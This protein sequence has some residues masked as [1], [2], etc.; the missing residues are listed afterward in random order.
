MPER[1]HQGRPGA[2]ERRSFPRPPLWL[3]LLLLLL[4]VGGLV[5]ARHHREQVSKR[6]AHVIAEE[7]RTPEDVRKLKSE[8]AEM[9]LGRGEL[10]KELDGRA[11]FL[12]GLKSEDFYLSIDTKSRKIRFFYGDTVLREGDVQIG[13]QRTISAG[14][15]QWT[16]IPLKGAFPVEAK[17]VSYDWP[18]PEWLSS[19]RRVVPNGLGRYVIFLPNGYAIH[20]P[21][22]E[23]SPLKGPKPGSY[24]VSEDMLRA[25]WPRIHKGRTLVYIF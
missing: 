2:S 20:T 10:Q 22:S 19:E 21:P 1:R 6:F 25:I 4:G 23:D 17:L 15:K 18:V 8:I 9:D 11:K 7:A 24:M 5:Y 12:A 14:D 13:D 16:F 3:T